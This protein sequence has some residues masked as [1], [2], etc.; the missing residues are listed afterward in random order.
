[1]QNSGNWAVNQSDR[2]QHLKR[3][4]DAGIPVID[5]GYFFRIWHN[6]VRHTTKNKPI[7]T[8]MFFD[9]NAI[10]NMRNYSATAKRK[11]NKSLG[12]TPVRYGRYFLVEDVKQFER[13][14]FI[15]PVLWVDHASPLYKAL[16]YAVPMFSCEEDYTL[17]NHL[18]D[19]YG[20]PGGGFGSPPIWE[21]GLNISML[22]RCVQNG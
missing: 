8:K 1:M 17:W 11:I 13:Q 18:L 2:D 21:L 7:L 3:W 12:R 6:D 9:Y 20:V 10:K 5:N 22:A 4:R 14:T 16:D 15:K 19:L